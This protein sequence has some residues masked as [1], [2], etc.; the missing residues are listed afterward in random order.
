MKE[1]LSLDEQG[2]GLE[3]EEDRDCDVVDRKVGV[4]YKGRM[5]RLVEWLKK[6]WAV[7]LLVVAV[8]YIFRGSILGE[9]RRGVYGGEMA[10]VGVLGGPELNLSK[11]VGN[12]PFRQEAPPTDSAE[13]MVVRDTSLSLQVK[14]VGGVV[15]R[16][17]TIS[18]EKG[19]FLVD[20]S[21]TR[22]EGASSGRITVRVPE[23]KRQEAMDEF[24]KLAVKTVSEVVMG[25]DVTD[26][27]V[28]NEARLGVLSRTKT[29]FEEI[30]AKAEKVQD[31]LQVQ[32][33]LINLQEQIDNLKGQQ[34]YLEQTAKLAKITVFLST[35]D[36]A[37]PYAPD[38]AWRPGIVF[39]YAVRSLVGTLRGV[40]NLVIWLGVYSVA[41][42]PAA[43]VIWWARRRGKRGV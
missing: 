14:D 12:M 13:R 35:D 43:G 21:L 30:L 23:T 24:K 25:T 38:K 6:Y 36:L 29:K 11:S 16:I 2:L 34:K 39:K 7:V 15:N 8:G 37:L 9:S 20:S 17:E 27:Y 42:V 28:D 1:Y 32:R 26:Q 19:G 4:E 22:P 5:G 40:G 33:E 31:L 41:W 18:R 3:K 10:D